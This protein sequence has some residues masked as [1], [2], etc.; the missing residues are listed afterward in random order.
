VDQDTLVSRTPTVALGS[1]ARE[2][3]LLRERTARAPQKLLDPPTARVNAR[4][5]DH[6]KM[7]RPRTRGTTAAGETKRQATQQS[8]RRQTVMMACRFTVE[9]CANALI[10]VLR[11]DA[12]MPTTPFK[13]SLLEASGTS[14]SSTSATSSQRSPSKLIPPPPPLPLDRARG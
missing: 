13:C 8:P 12:S 3:T 14:P 2:R 7:Q 5:E 11:F 4:S 10:P 1:L 6:V 9:R